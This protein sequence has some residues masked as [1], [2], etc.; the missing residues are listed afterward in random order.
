MPFQGGRFVPSQFLLPVLALVVY[1]VGATEFMLSPMLAPLGAAFDV[2]P[3]RAAW[4][5]SS[6]AFAYALAAP[7]FGY[8]SDRIDRRRLLLAALLLFA[9][10]GAALTLAPSFAAAIVF[11]VFGGLASAALIPTVFALI[12]DRM[13]S[14][15][16]AGA[17]GLVM[18]GMTL[19]IAL[20]PVVA[21]LLTDAFGWTAPFL[22][23]A[24]GCV[25][26]F[27]LGR[28]VIPV[29][30]ARVTPGRI[31]WKRLREWAILRPLVAKGAWNGTAVSAFLLSG[32]VLRLRYGF[33]AAE[34]GGAVS[35]FGIGLGF[36][37][38]GVGRI[39]RLCG[40]DEMTLT[41]ATLVVLCAVGLFLIVPVALAGSLL[42][43]G[44]WGAA[45]GVAAP[46]STAI[47]ASRAKED[48]GV[49][50]AISESL[51]NLTILAVLPLAAV[52]LEG[53]GVRG[54]AIV[55]GI[56]LSV[57]V[58]LTAWDLASSRSSENA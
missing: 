42:S 21:G 31:S 23:T 3:A 11:R 16:Q 38:F 37:N 58:G 20:G 25:G 10:D 4:L 51:N 7:V 28:S 52:V 15:R 35:A 24:A 12:A 26:T 44:V 5:V 39:S 48:K 17:M 43:L 1:F 41:L 27:A 55:F 2:T 49:V 36:G 6:Y 8:F 29:G 30:P 45:L 19:G 32:E 40:R 9:L 56:G 14:D 50:L 13:P 47:L 22:A 33:G 18:L 46:T 53:S 54:A 34:A 57:G